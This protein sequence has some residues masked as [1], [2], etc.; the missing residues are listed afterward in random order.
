MMTPTDLRFDPQR[1]AALADESRKAGATRAGLNDLL[2]SLRDKKRD[3]A[4]QVGAVNQRA[5]AAGPMYQ[6]GAEAEAKRL[7]RELADLSVNITLQEVETDEA[8][9]AAASARANFAS[10]LE[11]A[12]AQGLTIPSALMEQKS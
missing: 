1:L 5:A 3:L 8:A 12:K 10:A 4:S 6:A 11:F 2:H 9:V 7:Q